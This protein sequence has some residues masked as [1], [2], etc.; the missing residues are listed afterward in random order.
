MPAPSRPVRWAELR[1]DDFR[2]RLA[3][4]PVACLPLGLCEPHGHVAALGLDLIKAEY[5]C[6][7]AARRFGG[8]VAPSQGYHIH[9]C[10]FHAPWL[11]EV[12]G[13][14]NPFLAALPPHVMTRL[15]LYQLR[16]FANAGFRAV[17]GVSG[18]AG[19]SQ[20]DL[21]RVANAFTARTRLPVVVKTDP[22]WVAGRFRGDHA[23]RYEISQLLAIRPDLVDLN[24]LRRQQEP[25]SG[26]RLALG[27]DAVEA[28]AGEGRAINEAI[29][30]AIGAAVRE[31]RDAA[32]DHSAAPLLTYADME[33]IW[34]ALGGDNAPWHSA[35]PKP[36]QPPVGEAS[37]WKP[38]EHATLS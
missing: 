1:P 25:G 9:E 14:E 24:L 37:R 16:A 5:Y 10:G 12:V 4:C 27:E 6:E 23:G 26:G 35:S 20:E 30:E 11:E 36:G 22:E 15:F 7:E 13:E 31:L 17:I 2:A 3:A 33:A 29:I 38:C 34:S 21:R 18:H 28:T 19:G 32:K 8:I